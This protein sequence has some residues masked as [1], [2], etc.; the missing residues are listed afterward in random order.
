[1]N[2]GVMVWIVVMAF[3]RSAVSNIMRPH[4][5]AQPMIEPLKVRSLRVGLL[6]RADAKT[7]D[8]PRVRGFSRLLA[9]RN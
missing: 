5:Q 6:W 4:S 8:T 3:I 7:P 9:E 2:G 1:M